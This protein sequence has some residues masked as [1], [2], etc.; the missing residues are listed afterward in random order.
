VWEP[1]T[2]SD[3]ASAKSLRR[4]GLA[5]ALELLGRGE[6]GALVVARLDRLSRS[7]PDFYAVLERAKQARAGRWSAWTRRST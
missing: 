1:Q 2:F 5:M 4:P 3:T 6:A 7:V